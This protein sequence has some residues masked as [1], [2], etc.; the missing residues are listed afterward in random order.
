MRRICL[1][2]AGLALSLPAVSSDDLLSLYNR[3]LQA[4]PALLG[5][6]DTVDM[7]KA[8]EDQRLAALLPQISISGNYSF[9][10]FHSDPISGNPRSETSATYPG[11]RASI[12]LQQPI[13]DLQAYLLMKSQQAKT[14]QSEE[15]LLA[16]HQKLIADLI[17][18]YVDALE[19][20]DKS[21]IFATE[22]QSTVQQLARVKAM[23]ARQMAL[24][25]DL[26]ELEAH[27]ET[28]RTQLIDNDNNARI[29]LEKLR[30]L[31]GDAVSELQPVRLDIAQPPPEGSIDAWT[32][33]AG[34]LNP[35]LQSLKHAVES[36]RLSINAYRAG[37][38][39]RLELQVS[40][41]YS[42]TIYN[43][44]QTSPYDVTTAGVQA[45]VPVYD[46]S[47]TD[48]KIRE[49]SARN[50][51]VESQMEQKLRELEKQTRAAY[52][53]MQTS[54]ARSAATD[55]QLAAREKSRMAM[56]KGYGLGAVTIVDLLN[57]E[58]QLSSAKL[59]QR[60]ARYRYF[61]AR[62]L[63]YFQTGKLIGP[64]LAKFND[65]LVLRDKKP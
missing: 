60:Q 49:A 58:K 36:V 6:Q 16:A 41:S 11:A 1:F 62:S 24:I 59:E 2:W 15:D 12:N 46:G 53:D 43:N 28:L 52:L 63:L 26:Y 42:N 14:S 34:Q 9:N 55:R 32:Q 39:P 5:S 56:E 57:A 33:Q 19:A 13:F 47:N 29:A 17:D 7:L 54:P 45:T 18:R 22:L 48:A 44:R 50:K 20:N 3:A 10:Y 51:L 21:T 23:Q 40:E 31:T 8:Q 35:E 38:L 61:K 27:T 37:Y 4:S 65:W 30:E 64:E 25:T